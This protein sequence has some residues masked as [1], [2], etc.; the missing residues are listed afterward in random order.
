[1]T[2]QYNYNKKLNKFFS[3]ITTLDIYKKINLNGYSFKVFIGG[4]GKGKSHFAFLEMIEQIKKGNIVGYIRNTEIEIKQIKN[5][6]ANMI[7]EHTPYKK[8]SVSVENIID[9][10]TNKV[11]VASFL[12][13]TIIK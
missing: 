7:I 11:L 3:E 6:I 2:K 10:E 13:K 5:V 1:M 8:L 12:L 9:K 4:K